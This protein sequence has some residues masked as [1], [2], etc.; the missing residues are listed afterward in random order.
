MIKKLGEYMPSQSKALYVD[1]YKT[2]EFESF[3]FNKEPVKRYNYY[4]ILKKRRHILLTSLRVLKKKFRK[5]VNKNLVF[6]A[7]TSS[8]L[9]RISLKYIYV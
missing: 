6:M 8:L 7:I 9:Q 4:F 3:L 2:K 5:I 1:K